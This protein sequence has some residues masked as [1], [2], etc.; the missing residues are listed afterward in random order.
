VTT[1]MMAIA[2]AA[3]AL[4]G[5]NQAA[6]NESANVPAAAQ[7]QHP[8]YCFFKDAA[9]K[10]WSGSRD[11]SGNVTVQG[12]ARLEDRR[13]MAAIGDSETAGASAR[14]WL[15]MGPNTTGMGAEDN[16]WDVKFTVPSSAAVT[17]VTLLCGKKTVAQLTVPVKA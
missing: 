16:W 15:T 13:Y 4:A 5:C 11:S 3:A 2:A 8:T 9:T 10:G 6:E 1:R 12:K 7:V 17:G 14:L